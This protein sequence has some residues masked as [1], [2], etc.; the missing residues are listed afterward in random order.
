MG[1]SLKGSKRQDP[2]RAVSP[3]WLLSSCL[4]FGFF[5]PLFA[6]SL[7]FS[8]KGQGDLPRTP[9]QLSRVTTRAGLGCSPALVLSLTLHL[10][11]AT[12]LKPSPLLS[13]QKLRESPA[14]GEIR[15]SSLEEQEWRQSWNNRSIHGTLLSALMFLVQWCLF[16]SPRKANP[17]Y[18]YQK[19]KSIPSPGRQGSRVP[20]PLI[21]SR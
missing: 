14:M 11:S 9:V 15:G 17:V 2:A 18:F 12:T 21:R 3:T 1:F 6:D 10:V 19:L 5:I 8:V 16:K 13:F 7:P 20:F 4:S